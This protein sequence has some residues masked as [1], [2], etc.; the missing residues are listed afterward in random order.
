[1][2]ARL[3][4]AI[5]LG[6][7]LVALPTT[8]L[9]SS[10]HAATNSQTYPD[11]TGEDANAPDITSVNVTN[12]DAGNIVFKVNISNRPAL[13]SDMTMLM[14]F[15][16]DENASTG[17]QDSLGAEYAIELDP[18]S[19]NLFQWNGSDYLLAQQ[20]ADLTYS[21][22]ATGATIHL[23]QGDLAGTKGFNF[24]ILIFS[25]IVVDAQ[26]NAS[27]ANAHADAAPD[28]GHG[29]FNYKVI[30]KITLT[31]TAFTVTPARA[32]K[33]FQASLAAT[34]SDTGGPVGAGTVAC[35]ATVGGKALRGTHT[36]ANGIASCVWHLPKTA[37]GKTVRGKISLTVQGTTLSKSFVAHVH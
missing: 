7:A 20:Q 34:Q 2:K 5:A 14:F 3:L 15:D 30:A 8:A 33:V 9:G 1:M 12:D 10:S 32:G 19:V 17:D 23:S 4:L 18:G 31:Q 26:G 16:T 27:F 28:I 25:G 37:K 24:G 35:T 6:A 36:L 22:D 11:S 21:Y 29:F 13:T